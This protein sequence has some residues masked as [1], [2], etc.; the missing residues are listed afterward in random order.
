MKRTI[1]SLLGLIATGIVGVAMLYG[2]DVTDPEVGW[3]Y[4]CGFIIFVASLTSFIWIGT[5]AVLNLVA[6]GNDRQT[7]IIAAAV[8]ISTLPVVGVVQ[9]TTVFENDGYMYYFIL[10]Y[11]CLGLPSAIFNTGASVYYFV[12]W[13]YSRRSQ[14]LNAAAYCIA[15]GSFSLVLSLVGI[16]LVVQE[17]GNLWIIFLV[18]AV[19]SI[20]HIFIARY[21]RQQ[22]FPI[23]KV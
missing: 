11:F 8:T 18:A 22:I 4:I 12:S 1:L 20:P 23:S 10:A 5:K 19:I 15:D 16:W 6:S 3:Q 14:T 2:G 21:F 9:F 7:T 17:I 13:V